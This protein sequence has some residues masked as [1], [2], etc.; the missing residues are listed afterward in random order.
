MKKCFQN[1]DNLYQ[2]RCYCIY[3]KYSDIGLNSADPDKMQQNKA[4]VQGLHGLPVIQQFLHVNGSELHLF[5]FY[6]RYG[7]ELR[8]W[9]I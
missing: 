1:G 2:K 3:P 6:D 7:T 4:S 5:K 9:N 8:C